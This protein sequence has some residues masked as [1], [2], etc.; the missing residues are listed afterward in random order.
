LKYILVISFETK[1][2]KVT[3]PQA[4]FVAAVKTFWAQTEVL[5]GV[6]VEE[7]CVHIFG[8]GGVGARTNVFAL[9]I[10]KTSTDC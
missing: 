9:G 2:G 7:S 3:D 6:S 10:S 8:L 4:Q 5:G 1:Q